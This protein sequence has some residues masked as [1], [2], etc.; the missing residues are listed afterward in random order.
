M[1]NR[2]IL[3]WLLTVGLFCILLSG[4]RTQEP[5]VS[6]SYMYTEDVQFDRPPLLSYDGVVYLSAS[7][8]TEELLSEC[9]YLGVVESCVPG[10]VTPGED[11]QANHPITG[12]EVYRRLSR[13]DCLVIRHNG[14]CWTYYVWSPLVAEPDNG[15]ETKQDP[16]S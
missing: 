15:I 10:E 9:E 4:C 13:D 12:A 1:K 14:E 7:R 16:V 11:L 3:V 6:N 8:V 2:W 5:A